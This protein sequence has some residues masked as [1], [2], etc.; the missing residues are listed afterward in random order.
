MTINQQSPRGP[1]VMTVDNV[2]VNKGLKDA[3]F[4]TQ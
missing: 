4:K 1:M 2:K 3:D